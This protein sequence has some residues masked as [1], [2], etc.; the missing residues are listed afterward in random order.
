MQT[1]TF[2]L[3][4][5]IGGTKTNLALFTRESGANQPIA[6][7]TFRS[8]DYPNLQVIAAQ[9]LESHQV[10]VSAAVFGVAGPVESGSVTATN[11]PWHM[12][13]TELS[14][15]LEIANVHLMNDLVA[16]ATAVP[17]LASFDLVTLNPGKPDPVGPIAVIAPGTG[18][19][20][21]FLLHDGTTYRAFPSEGGHADFAP[22]SSDEDGLLVYM[23][24]QFNHVSWERVCSGMA[25]PHLYG[26]ACECSQAAQPAWLT[27]KLK[28]S[29]DPT[30]VI[31]QTALDPVQSDDD[32]RRALQLFVSILGTEAGNM[33]LK[34]LATGGIYLGGGLPPRI[35]S[36]L[37]GEQFLSA[38]YQKG[39][40]RS[41]MERVPVRVILN[42]Q[43]A[44]LGAAHYGLTH[45]LP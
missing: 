43:S 45:F 24:R 3:A 4:G 6:E 41:F 8:A 15:A 36:L 23:R 5:D 13:E 40:F 35:L 17:V 1:S 10:K 9:F 25:I 42:S 38:F 44:L 39:R 14:T 18:L 16:I 31:L 37:Q 32:C 12:N 29:I 22:G 33:A 19:G 11:L 26:Y 20:E 7:A 30:P 27:E 2:L 28:A 34:F 21:A